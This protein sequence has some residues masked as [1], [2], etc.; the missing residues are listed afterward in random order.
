MP[1]VAE[2][3]HIESTEDERILHTIGLERCELRAAA[4]DKSQGMLLDGSRGKLGIIRKIIFPFPLQ[5]VVFQSGETT[6]FAFAQVLAE[7][8]DW[9]I[10]SNVSHEISIA[11]I[12]RKSLVG[13]PDF[14]A[15]SA[16]ASE[17]VEAAIGLPN[18]VGEAL[19]GSRHGR[20]SMLL[21]HS[22][23]DSLLSEV[24]QR[25]QGHRHTRGARTL[26]A[27]CQNTAHTGG[28]PTL[29]CAWPASGTRIRSGR[30]P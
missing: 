14:T 21:N 6:F 13:T 23:F 1:P 22:P 20:H 27:F 24:N 16:V 25:R 3:I 7:V 29:T 17:N 9:C 15:A 10:Q 18:D 4:A 5:P 12:A 28:I 26:W 19:V 2:E 11:S 8:F 30:I